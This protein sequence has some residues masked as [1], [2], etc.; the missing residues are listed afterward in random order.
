MGFS[1]YLFFPS[2]QHEAV[3]SAPAVVAHRAAG[4]PALP[5]PLGPQL[6]LNLREVR[7]ESA[8]R[9]SGSLAACS[10]EERTQPAARLRGTVKQ[11]SI[12]SD[13]WFVF[14]V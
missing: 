9:V 14:G 4:G 5:P 3:C 6:S 7:W 2:V 13:V 1:W 12:F 11:V 10:V 8:R